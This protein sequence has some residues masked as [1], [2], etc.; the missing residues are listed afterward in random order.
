MVAGKFDT[1]GR[2]LLHVRNDQAGRGRQLQETRAQVVDYH[3]SNNKQQTQTLAKIRP[4][5]MW[6]TR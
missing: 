4:A 1:N 2:L 3:R 6:I 5:E